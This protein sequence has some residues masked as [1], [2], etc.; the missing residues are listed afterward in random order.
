MLDLI[1]VLAF[2]AYAIYSGF[3]SKDEAGKNLEEYFLAGKT[4]KGW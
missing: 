1:I 2:I 4:L 3:Q